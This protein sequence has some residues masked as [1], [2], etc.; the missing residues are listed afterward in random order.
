MTSPPS[1]CLDNA[2]VNSFCESGIISL[3]S[4]RDEKPVD[5]GPYKNS[6]KC[7]QL[8]E[9]Q[10]RIS[11][12]E[13]IG[14]EMPQ[15]YTEQKRGRRVLSLGCELGIKLHLFIVRQILFQNRDFCNFRIHYLASGNSMLYLMERSAG[16]LTCMAIAWKEFPWINPSA[17]PMNL[18]ESPEPLYSLILIS[19]A[20]HVVVPSIMSVEGI[21]LNARHSPILHSCAQAGL[22]V[23]I[24]ITIA[25]MAFRMKRTPPGLSERVGL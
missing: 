17:I 1:S 16:F 24:A 23:S 12:I 22:A 6:P 25:K 21:G 4:F 10:A 11:D 18:A 14:A 15:E 13:S 19:P 8:G 9:S 20:E 2:I 7:K 5:D 3:G